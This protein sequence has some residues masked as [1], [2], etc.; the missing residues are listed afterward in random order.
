LKL[1]LKPE[2][3]DQK[4]NIRFG[5]KMTDM[6]RLMTNPKDGFTEEKRIRFKKKNLVR[7]TQKSS[8]FH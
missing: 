2:G 8:S 4:R 1:L 7:R 5:V 3:P 6:V